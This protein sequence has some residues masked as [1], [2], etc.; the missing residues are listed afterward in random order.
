MMTRATI[1]K[2]CCSAGGTV[3][4]ALISSVQAPVSV[5]AAFGFAAGLA[6]VLVG[7]LHDIDW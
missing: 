2:L 5:A 4:G 3:I 7:F 6:L 1:T